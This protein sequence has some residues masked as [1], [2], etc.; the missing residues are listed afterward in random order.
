MIVMRCVVTRQIKCNVAARLLSTD[1]MSLSA[2]IIPTPDV[3]AVRHARRRSASFPPS[4]AQV[5]WSHEGCDDASTAVIG[6]VTSLRNVVNV[7]DGGQIISGLHFICSTKFYDVSGYQ[8]V[9]LIRSYCVHGASWRCKTECIMLKHMVHIIGG[10]NLCCVGSSRYT[11]I[12]IY[13][14]CSALAGANQNFAP[15]RASDTAVNSYRC[16]DQTYISKYVQ[17]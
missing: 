14:L 7:T 8:Y 1:Y 11:Y 5:E 2:T 16:P 12:Y 3:L 4:V 13:I 9:A 17:C 6:V 15:C 10:A